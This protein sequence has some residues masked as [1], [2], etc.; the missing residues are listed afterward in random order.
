MAVDC[1]FY[2]VFVGKDAIFLDVSWTFP[3]GSPDISRTIHGQFPELPSVPQ[4]TA[5]TLKTFLFFFTRVCP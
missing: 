4:F 3:R 2:Y 1:V 5:H